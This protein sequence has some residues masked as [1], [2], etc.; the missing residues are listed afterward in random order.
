MWWGCGLPKSGL[1][2]AT[3]AHRIS[4]LW[5]PTFELF[6]PEHEM[7]MHF[8]VYDDINVGVPAML[9][10]CQYFRSLRLGFAFLHFDYFFNNIWFIY[11]SRSTQH[12]CNQ[13]HTQA[14][15]AYLLPGKESFLGQTDFDIRA[16]SRVNR[17]YKLPLKP[18]TSNPVCTHLLRHSIFSLYAGSS[19]ENACPLIAVFFDG[20]FCFVIFSH[21]FRCGLLFFL[22]SWRS[23]PGCPNFCVANVSLASYISNGTSMT[24]VTSFPSVTNAFVFQLNPVWV[25]RQGKANRFVQVAHWRG[26]GQV[27]FKA[28]KLKFKA[29]ELIK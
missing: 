1:L 12:S 14:A 25:G 11:C 7:V 15:Y 16:E 3:S 5:N 6:A 9:C 10:G 13:N 8:N 29:F 17:S 19:Q 2:E 4:P 27:I 23:F 28:R 21:P 20:T 18:R 24:N 26:G 22:K